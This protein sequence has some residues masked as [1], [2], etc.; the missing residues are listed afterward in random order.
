MVD[1]FGPKPR[2]Y[3]YRVNKKKRRLA[4]KSVLSSKVLE[5][6]LVVLDKLPFKRNQN[7]KKW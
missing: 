7:K 1:G 6:Q 4:I 3:K 5:N 2:S